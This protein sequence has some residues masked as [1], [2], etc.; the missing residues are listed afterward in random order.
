M[1]TIRLIRRIEN[2][3][4]APG[5]LATESGISPANCPAIR[6]ATRLGIEILSPIE[7]KFDNSKSFN[8]TRAW[9]Q[10][11]ELILIPGI[12]GDPR[13]RRTYARIDSGF[14]ILDSNVPFLTTLP[15]SLVDHPLGYAQPNVLYEVGYSGPLLVP[16]SATLPATISFG[17]PICQLLPLVEEKVDVVVDEDSTLTLIHPEFEGLLN[18]DWPNGVRFGRTV[19]PMDIWMGT[20]GDSV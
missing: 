3:D 5:R 20:E 1:K 12:I 9:T 4:T 13:S 15:T 2:A 10:E 11:N 18:R 16:L 8:V 19:K 7:V 6:A 14:S 17:D